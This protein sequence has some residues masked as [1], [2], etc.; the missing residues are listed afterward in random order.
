VGLAEETKMLS[1]SFY[2]VGSEAAIAGIKPTYDY[3]Y[4]EA[5]NMERRLE[6]VKDWLQLPAD[7]RPHLITFYLPQVDHAGHTFGTSCKRNGRSVHFVDDAL[8]SLQRSIATLNLP[9]NYIFVS[10]MV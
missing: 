3:N 1:A 5:I 6:I 10:D 2:W 8:A 9:V 7:K 4:N